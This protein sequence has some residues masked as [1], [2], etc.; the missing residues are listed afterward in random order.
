MHVRTTALMAAFIPGASP[1]EVS[2]PILVTF[3]SKISKLPVNCFF[4]SRQKYTFRT[5]YD[6]KIFI[7]FIPSKKWYFIINHSL[8]QISACC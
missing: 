8:L 5:I 1:P 2:T 3:L 6:A 4:K 7:S